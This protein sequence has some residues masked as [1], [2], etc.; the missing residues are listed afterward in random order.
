MSRSSILLLL[1]AAALLHVCAA[2]EK[3]PV[4][5][6]LKANKDTTKAAELLQQLYPKPISENAKLTFLVPSNDVSNIFK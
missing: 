1:A 3:R 6:W 4:I 2:Q 5:D